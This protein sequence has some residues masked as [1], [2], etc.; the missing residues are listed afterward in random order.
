MIAVDIFLHTIEGSRNVEVCTMEKPA[1][2]WEEDNVAVQKAREDV[3]W[4]RRFSN[5][6][7]A[8]H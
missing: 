4:S 7:E 5:V 8:Y 3:A 2:R 1:D 6:L